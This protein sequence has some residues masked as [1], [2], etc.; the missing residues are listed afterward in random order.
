VGGRRRVPVQRAP[1]LWSRMTR[2]SFRSLPER[3][4]HSRQCPIDD[5]VRGV[6]SACLLIEITQNSNERRA[7]A[8]ETPLT[9]T[10]TVLPASA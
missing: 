6:L 3:V 10:V 7:L 1:R 5:M 2:R 9:L 8:Y 4:S